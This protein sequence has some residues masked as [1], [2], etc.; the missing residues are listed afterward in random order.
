MTWHVL[1]LWDGKNLN[2]VCKGNVRCR[3]GGDTP[4]KTPRRWAA[5]R[6]QIPENDQLM[7]VARR[8]RARQL[9]RAYFGEA[10]FVSLTSAPTSVLVVCG[11]HTG[12]R[13]GELSEASSRVDL[14]TP[15][16]DQAMALCRAQ[17]TAAI[18]SQDAR[19]QHSSIA[20]ARP[21]PAHT[22]MGRSQDGPLG[23]GEVRV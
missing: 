11:V 14:P 7:G 22:K 13:N 21:L 8:H 15:D 19:R 10:S 4:E 17:T 2:R 12:C 9:R 18:I 5:K 20:V 16:S 6:V 3:N 1:R 23:S